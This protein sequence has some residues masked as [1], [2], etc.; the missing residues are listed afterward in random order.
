M[1]LALYNGASLLTVT[2]QVKRLPRDLAN[3][4][5]LRNHVTILQITPSLFHRFPERV[6]ATGLLGDQSQV[7]VLAFGGEKFPPLGVLAE[8]KTDLVIIA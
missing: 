7:R 6:I 1:F 8:K 2:S 4:L 3:V 5:F